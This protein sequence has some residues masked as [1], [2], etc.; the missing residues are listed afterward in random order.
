M[1]RQKGGAGWAVGV[2]IREVVEALALDKRAVLPISVYQEGAL[3]IRDVCLSLPTIVDRSGAA[4]VIEPVVSDSERELLQ[5]SAD[6]L[7]DV[8]AKVL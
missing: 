8:L 4:E 6:S 7:R 5:K 2:S 3:G 1:I